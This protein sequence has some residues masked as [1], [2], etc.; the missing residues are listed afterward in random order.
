M[1]HIV[2]NFT[3]LLIFFCKKRKVPL[4]T[5]I[6][7]IMQFAILSIFTMYNGQRYENEWTHFY[8]TLCTMP[9]Y[10]WS[11]ENQK[12]YLLMMTGS[13]KILQIK[14]FDTTAINYIL[15]LKIWKYAY[16]IVGAVFKI[17]K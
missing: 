4:G 17:R 5:A 8:E 12:T 13:S 15:L 1:V 3:T 2:V 9:W 16:S 11:L 14:V 7:S 6:I 10:K